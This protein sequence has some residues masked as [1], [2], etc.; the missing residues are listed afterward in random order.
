MN[1]NFK[2]ATV[3][4]PYN[5]LLAALEE[6][7]ELDILADDKIY[8]E[9]LKTIN[10]LVDEFVNGDLSLKDA[11]EFEFFKTPLGSMVI[12]NSRLVAKYYER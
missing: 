7:K 3:T 12:E 9:N 5:D 6:K 4:M 2:N 1:K 8:K 11:K 10:G